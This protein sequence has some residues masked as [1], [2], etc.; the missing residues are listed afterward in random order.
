MIYLDNA[1]SSH[2]KPLE[3]I[4]A[5]T[6]QLRENGANP[7]RSG[8]TLSDA[9]AQT[10][11]SARKALAEAFGTEPETVIFTANTTDAINRALYGL[12]PP[13]AHVIISDLEHNSVLRPLIA[14]KSRNVT[15]SVAETCEDDAQT[16]KNFRSLFRRET[17]LVICTHA[18]NVTGQILPVTEI[19]KLC[20][21]R[22]ILFGVDAAQTA[23]TLRYDLRST[24]IDF[25]CVPGHKSLLGPQGTGALIL[26]SPLRMAP[27][28]QG[29]TG[30]DSL[31]R[32]QPEFFPEGYESGTLNTPGIAGLRE[33]VLFTSR[34]GE[35]IRKHESSLRKLFLEMIS[36]LSAYRVLGQG[37][38]FVSTVAL[39]HETVPSEVLARRL[40]ERG[41]CT[42]GGYQ[43]SALAHEKLG[44]EKSGALRISFGF[45]N[46]E[47]DV[48]ECVKYLKNY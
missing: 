41:I 19:G 46:T 10:V 36:R 21:E 14:L 31:L 45:R 2:P 8:H 9:A 17:A 32:S 16:V 40:D 35:A 15:F 22:G 6:R 39:L 5:V 7:G 1:A 38:R 37:E 48:A 24:P 44:T 34:Y 47:H 30:S 27:L 12:L 13:G 20:R 3:V 23:G 11:F 25:L 4:Q 29:G 33:G 42:R 18:S 28:T 26:A 43:C